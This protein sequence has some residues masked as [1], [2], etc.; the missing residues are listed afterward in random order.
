MR[1]LDPKTQRAV[2]RLFHDLKQKPASSVVL[3]NKY[4]GE[5]DYEALRTMDLR[6]MGEMLPDLDEETLKCVFR[7]FDDSLDGK[8]KTCEFLMAVAMLCQPCDSPEE[9]MQACFHMFDLDESGCLSR[10]EFCAMIRASVAIDLTTLL[11]TNV[12][13]KHLE[14]QLEKEH[15][16]ETIRFWRAA[17]EFRNLSADD[18]AVAAEAICGQYVRENSPEEV[19]LPATQRKAILQAVAVLSASDEPPPATL[20]AAAET[21]MFNLMERNAFARLRDDP[22][23]LN[24]LADDFFDRADSDGDGRVRYS[25]YSK[26]A[27]EQPQV[28]A[29]FGQLRRT[30]TK[31]VSGSMANESS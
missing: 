27:M 3:G 11:L 29:F 4:V 16:Q 6:G 19:N 13:E 10:D 20:F 7:F 17:V 9:Q 5:A 14:L 1:G 12:G 15:A 31:L 8:I 25:E 26:W 23:M 28:L 30:I 22:E 21:E 18:R 24:R 2:L